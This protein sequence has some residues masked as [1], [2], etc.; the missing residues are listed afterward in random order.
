MATHTLRKSRQR[1]AAGR[2]AGA[3]A[4]I[5]ALKSSPIAQLRALWAQ[6]HDG[7]APSIR[8]R[9]VLMRMLAWDI[10]ANILGGFDAR[11]GQKLM[12]IADTLDSGRTYEAAVKREVGIGAVLTREWR[13]VVHTAVITAKGVE[14]EGKIYRSLSDVARTITGTRWSG[15]RFF[16]LDQRP[17]KKQ[18]SLSSGEIA[19]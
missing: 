4:E 5:E 15:P 11:T 6:C 16:G 3:E 10:Q 1:N 12:Q 2:L 17:T 19:A 18:T 8:S 14:Y 7:G 9:E 13:G